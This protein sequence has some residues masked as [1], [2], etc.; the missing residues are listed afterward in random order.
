MYFHQRTISE[1][2]KVPY[3]LANS[4]QAE[5][6][7][8]WFKPAV[9]QSPG[10][11]LSGER[12]SGFGKMSQYYWEKLRGEKSSSILGRWPKGCTEGMQSFG[13][14]VCV[15]CLLRVKTANFGT[16]FLLCS[17]ALT[18]D[19]QQNPTGLCL[20]MNVCSLRGEQDGCS[21]SSVIPLNN[22]IM[23]EQKPW[24]CNLWLWGRLSYPNKTSSEWLL[25]QLAFSSA[26]FDVGSQISNR[27]SLWKYCLGLS[28]RRGLK[29]LLVNLTSKAITAFSSA[30]DRGSTHEKL[31]SWYGWCKPRDLSGVVVFCFPFNYGAS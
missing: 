24:W 13:P 17:C 11:W 1:V 7:L 6:V 22:S 9:H 26:G 8:Q 5:R 16:S 19:V 29:Q 3:L 15:D 25:A 28:L 10:G 12:I 23:R 20:C 30:E 21:G 4:G 31:S 2:W 18:W 14:V 27:L